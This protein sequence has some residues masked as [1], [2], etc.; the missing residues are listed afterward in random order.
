MS[1]RPSLLI[2]DEPTTA[3][4]VTTQAG[5][6]ELLIEMQSRYGMALLLISHDLALVSNICSRLVVLFRGA[7]VET[8]PTEAI[9]H[10]PAHSYTRALV[11]ATPILEHVA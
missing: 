7:I 5:I 9:I 8:G 6:V 11:E 4:D 3:L 2:A 10:A 1:L